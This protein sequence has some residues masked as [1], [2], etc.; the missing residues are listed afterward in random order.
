[1]DNTQKVRTTILQLC[2]LLIAYL[3][4]C[5]VTAGYLTNHEAFVLFP[6]SKQ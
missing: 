1:M 5:K 3:L 4:S 6:L 2:I